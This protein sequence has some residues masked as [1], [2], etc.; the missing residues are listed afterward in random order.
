MVMKISKK[1]RKK[2]EKRVVFVFFFQSL[3]ARVY[4]VEY[5]Y[6]NVKTEATENMIE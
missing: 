3:N 2:K 6:Q 1:K 5:A 4:Y